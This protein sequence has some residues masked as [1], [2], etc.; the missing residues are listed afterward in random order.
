MRKNGYVMLHRKV[1]DWEWYRDRNTK[2]LFFHLLLTVNIQETLWNGV[3]IPRGAR[4]ASY[5]IL[6]Q[7]LG[8]TVKEIRTGCG[9]LERTGELARQSYPKFTVFTVVHYDSYQRPGKVNGSQRAQS[10]AVKGH[11]EGQ[12]NNKYKKNTTYSKEIKE[13]KKGAG[14]SGG[15]SPERTPG[16]KS[17][18][19]RMRE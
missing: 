16:E 17:I 13:E 1:L 10:G 7:E 18:Y 5:A 2:S 19:E 6:A 12:Q 15:G 11:A 8:M 4:V 3:K 14:A 9:H